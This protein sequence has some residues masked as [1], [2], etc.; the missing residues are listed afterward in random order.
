[1]T[2]SLILAGVLAGTMAITAVGGVALAQSTPT[3][4]PTPSATAT[5]TDEARKSYT[6]RLAAKLGISEEALKDAMQSVRRE[7]QDEKVAEILK[8]MV[9]AGK[10]TQEQ[11]DEY[12][13]WRKSRPE[14]PLPL[15]GAC[16]HKPHLGHLRHAA[17]FRGGDDDDDKKGRPGIRAQVSPGMRAFIND[18]P[19]EKVKAMLEKAVE[20]GRLTQAQADE[21]SAW[22]KARES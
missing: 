20:S 22:L 5:A 17:P 21:Y 2:K 18:I 19:D 15:L 9:E 14:G 1:M 8:R 11:G 7:M 13:E 16:H 10:L 4:T 12:L 3:G 6:A